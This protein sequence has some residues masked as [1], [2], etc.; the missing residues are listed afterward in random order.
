MARKKTT[1]TA[2]P[3]VEAAPPA[4]EPAALA[5]TVTLGRKDLLERVRVASGAKK[6]DV[7][8]I[9]EATLALMGEALARGE[10]LHLP[11]FGVARVTRGLD[12]GEGKSL[13]VKLRRAKVGDRPG[14]VAKE[15]LAVADEAD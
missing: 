10:V 8:S 2:V 13:V 11:P 14:R 3:A 5:S 12:G 4:P 7:K 6:K 15:T 9:V 1:K